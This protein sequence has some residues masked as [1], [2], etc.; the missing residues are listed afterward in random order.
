MKWFNEISSQLFLGLF[1]NY[2]NLFNQLNS[3]FNENEYL[4]EKKIVPQVLCCV[5]IFAANRAEINSC[6]K[7]V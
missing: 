6:K 3:N 4:T 7:G 1:S 5:C 2:T